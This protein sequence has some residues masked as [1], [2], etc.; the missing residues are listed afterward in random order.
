[1]IESKKEN[2]VATAIV[3]LAA[4][5]GTRMASRLPKVLHEV[6]NAALLLHAWRISQELRPAK[7]VIVIGRDCDEIKEFAAAKGI[8][9]EFAIQNEPRGTGDAVMAARKKLAGFEGS[10][11]VLYAD[12]PFVQH[13]SLQR[14]L[15]SVR[16][17]SAVS[18]LGFKASDPAG[19]GRL[20]L[21][22]DDSLW[23]IVEDKD[24]SA[25]ERLVN[26]CNSGVLCASDSLLFELLG[27][28]GTSN[29]AKEV[30]LTDV[31]EIA[32][33][34][35]H[36]CQAVECGEEETLGVN[37][38]VE[39]AAAETVFQSR[40]RIAAMSAGATL[41]QPD[42]VYFSFDTKLENDAIVEPNVVFGP[43]VF[44]RR[45]A[46]IRSFSYL[47]G[48]IVGIDAVV[49][50]FARLRPGTKLSGN[51]RVGNFVEIKA[52]SVGRGSKVPHLSYV[53]DSVVG[54]DS[55]FGAGTITCNYDGVSKHE[56]VVGDNVFLGSNSTLIAP[57]EIG[58]RSMVG[59]GSVVSS[60][61]PP[62]A[63]AISRARQSNR[64]GMASRIMRR[65]RKLKTE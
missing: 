21:K 9:A 41:V 44:V 56:T 1:M 29:A 60:N 14:L 10:I 36:D 39:L 33:R 49:G 18:V 34:R 20:L 30:Y 53:G 25:S 43:G 58:D 38:R 22:S 50:P 4:G 15:S 2:R 46:R 16:Q 63:L 42:S 8:N 17:G 5:K 3:I 64:P 61:V 54:E 55:N 27:Q 7:T 62:D 65:L 59:A 19:Y 40:A 13:A 37:S 11:I 6:G 51:T 26:F 32:R 31:V 35:G 45:G 23:K 28:I 47:E 12:T 57:I 52:S 24:A 48:C